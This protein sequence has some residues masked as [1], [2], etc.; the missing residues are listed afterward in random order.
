MSDFII[1]KKLL[2]STLTPM[3]LIAGTN[4]NLAL[5]QPTKTQSTIPSK[6]VTVN[7]KTVQV[8]DFEQ[9]TFE[10][11]PPTT[12][13]G[14]LIVP[15][16]VI[17]DLGFDPS[18][19]WV[20]GQKPQTFLK[21]GSLSG[22]GIQKLSIEQIG[23]L[24]NISSD[25]Q[26]LNTFQPIEW[27]SADSLLQ[28]MPGLSDTPLQDVGPL[29]SLFEKYG[30][31]SDILN[32]TVG[33]AVQSVPEVAKKLLGK[34]LDLSKYKLNDIPGLGQVPLQEFKGWSAATVA[35]IPSLS[36]VRW[37]DFPTPPPGVIRTV[38]P[39]DFTGSKEETMSKEAIPYVI[40]GSIEPKSGLRTI[41]VPPPIGQKIPYVE[42]A[43]YFGSQGPSY[44]GRW[45]AGSQHVSGGY[46]ILRAVNGGKEPTGL[47]TY[48]PLFKVSLNETDET[49][50]LATFNIS[51]R[52]CL[53]TAVFDYGCTPYSIATVPWIPARET[54]GVPVTAS[55]NGGG[56]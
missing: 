11:L 17:D 1:A 37:K 14:S 16:K 55:Y 46:G 4:Q 34:E 19:A 5:A 45:F 20:A 51:F 28:A 12:S 32:S 22:L 54:E 15:Q 18:T 31:S 36:Q 44:G 40:S 9:T 49:K 52:F 39:I 7:G 10:S 13:S 41:P 8:P 2:L 56:K 29:L 3:L 43:D 27:Q 6:T 21:L 47:A 53:K 26:K 35:G 42:L 33:N 24:T 38:A 50:G 23:Y 48:G 25:T 30:V